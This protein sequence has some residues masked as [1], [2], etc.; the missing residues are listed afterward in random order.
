MDV[1]PDHI[2][3]EALDLIADRVAEKLQE[4]LLASL[5]PQLRVE[6]MALHLGDDQTVDEQTAAALLGCSARTMRRLRDEDEVSYGK[7]GKSPRYSLGALRRFMRRLA[8][9]EIDTQ[10]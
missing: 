9:E 8:T 2:A 1:R 3:P 5:L 4:S 10:A 6:L 7:L